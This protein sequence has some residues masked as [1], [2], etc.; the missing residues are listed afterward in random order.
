[1]ADARCRGVKLADEIKTCDKW[2]VICVDPE[3]LKTKEWREISEYSIFR[4]RIIYAAA[5]E[6][7]LI[8]LW[9]IDFRRD[10]GTIGRWVRGRLPTTV[11]I[12]GLTATLAPGKDTAAV[13]QSLGFFEGQFHLIRRTNERP[14]IQ[15]IL[16][17]LTHGLAGYEFPDILPFLRSGRKLIIPFHSLDM[18]Y[19]CYVYIWR[20]QPASANKMRRTRMYTSL[21]SAEYNEETIR[22]M[23]EDPEFQI[24]LATIAFSNGINAK[25]LLDSLTLGASASV[26]IMVQEKGRTGREEG[27]LARGVVFV[28]K[29]TITL[30]NKTIA[31]EHI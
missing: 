3:H 14:N 4:Q 1:L 23:D 2:Q 13:C 16:Q 29:S 20:L 18:L 24:I 6:V 9:G 7:H 17:T 12:L 22:L 31:G 19:R 5:D 11:S 21:C 8:N 10:F 15:I 26:D 25:A 28:Q 27:T 30:A